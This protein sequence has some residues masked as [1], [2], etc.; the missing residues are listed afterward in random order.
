MKTVRITLRNPATDD[1][2]TDYS[3]S[4]NDKLKYMKHSWSPY[5]TDPAFCTYYNSTDETDRCRPFF[6]RDTPR[7]NS[8]NDFTMDETVIDD[9]CQITN[10]LDG[11]EDNKNTDF[12]KMDPSK[13]FAD[14]AQGY[15]KVV[16]DMV[17]V[18]KAC[19]PA[20]SRRML[21]SNTRGER[22]L[23]AGVV[24]YVSD[25][26]I[27]LVNQENNTVTVVKTDPAKSSTSSEVIVLAVGLGVSASI[28]FCFGIHLQTKKA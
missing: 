3:W 13:W 7:W 24:T 17:G 14:S 4:V 2:I 18:L 16:I 1:F 15:L 11:F 28:L 25:Q 22:Q 23:T 5:F 21:S 8:Y 27:I 12:W 9:V 10:T 6:E 19:G 26:L 20:T